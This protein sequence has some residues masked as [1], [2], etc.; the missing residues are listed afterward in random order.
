[1]SGQDKCVSYVFVKSL[2]SLSL[3]DELAQ[4]AEDYENGTSLSNSSS[5]SRTANGVGAS[6]I[7]SGSNA[8][9]SVCEFPQGPTDA[10]LQEV[11][12]E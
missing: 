10:E 3:G 8:A 5:L 12:Y 4:A 11:K 6:T 7:F 1:M 9:V 2:A